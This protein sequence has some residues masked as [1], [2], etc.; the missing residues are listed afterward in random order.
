MT[1]RIERN[2]RAALQCF[3]DKDFAGARRLC[4]SILSVDANHALAC[5]MLST[6]ELSDG[7]FRTATSL[8]LRAGQH[9]GAIPAQWILNI[10]WA[11]MCVGEGQAAVALLRAREGAFV[12]EP[13]TLRTAASEMS[14]LDCHEDANRLLAQALSLNGGDSVLHAMYG[15]NLQS[16]GRIGPARS[17][18]AK[19]TELDPGN[20]VA[21][22]SLAKVATRDDA[23]PRIARLLRLHA[24]SAPNGE[25]RVHYCFALFHELDRAGDTDQAWRFLAEGASVRSR[26]LPY[27]AA[28][29]AQL[30]DAIIANTPEGFL[31]GDAAQASGAAPIFIVGMP[32]TGPTLV[33][34]IPGNPPDV[35]ICGELN[36]LRMQFKWTTDHHCPGYIDAIGAGKL[37]TMDYAM[38]GAR[39][40]EKTAWRI[41]GK[42]RFSDKNQTNFLFCGPILKAIPH[43]RI[44][45]LRRNAMD[46]CFSNFKEL[47]TLPNYAYSYSL[48]GLAHHYRNYSRLMAHWHQVAPG[49][50]LDVSYESLVREPE[51]EAERLAGFCGLRAVPRLAEIEGNLKPVSTASSAQVLEPIHARFVDGWRRYEPQ[52]AR[53]QELLGTSS[54]D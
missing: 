1:L 16:L 50:I 12:N 35:A 32:P 36:D 34:R 52:L 28:Q 38:L 45:H 15:A 5:W 7:H 13:A 42:S 24:A 27:D 22:W 54:G 21:H 31:A 6:M 10:A 53:L 46:S 43:A 49:R 4:D 48:E 41:A 47:F 17:H 8:A 20:H 11:M 30:F 29:E 37:P 19:A 18:L 3:S 40:L 44:I 39:Y 14:M 23:G 2:W 26:Q 51:A 25:A 9:A 33:E